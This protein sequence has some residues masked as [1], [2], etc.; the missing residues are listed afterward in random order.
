MR[1]AVKLPNL[2]LLNS[3]FLCLAKKYVR[4]GGGG[5]GKKPNYVTQGLLRIFNKSIMF[6][7][8]NNLF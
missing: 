1:C 2:A 3:V 7:D 6:H 5:G 4:R 8:Q